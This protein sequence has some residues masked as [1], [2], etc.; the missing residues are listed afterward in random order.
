MHNADNLIPFVGR[1]ASRWREHGFPLQTAGG[2]R[3]RACRFN[4]TDALIWCSSGTPPPSVNIHCALFSVLAD[5]ADR[6]I[7]VKS[8]NIH[9]EYILFLRQKKTK[10]Q[11]IRPGLRH[12]YA[13]CGTHLEETENRRAWSNPPVEG[14]WIFAARKFGGC[15][16]L[17]YLR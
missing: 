4:L 9:K 12:S 7:V 1:A 11:K 8:E 6:S 14:N 5:P 3:P 15:L 2:R 16:I 10:I 13:R 17:K